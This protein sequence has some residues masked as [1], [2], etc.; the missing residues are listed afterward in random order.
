VTSCV[1]ES[2]V[3]C[4]DYGKY[5]V[6][7]YDKNE[8]GERR[9]M[10]GAIFYKNIDTPTTEV[11][12]YSCSLKDESPSVITERV[13]RLYPGLYR[14]Y[15]VLRT[16]QLDNI[17]DIVKMKNLDL[18]MITDVVERV[19]KSGENRVMFEYC[20][21]NSMIEAKCTMDQE[22]MEEYYIYDFE[23]SAPDDTDIL[24][25]LD[26]GICNYATQITDFYDHFRY[27]GKKDLFEY[28]C[29]PVLSGNFLNFK[30]TIKRE[31]PQMGSEISD[32]IVL[33]TR[34]YL[35][36]NIEQGKITRF[37]FNVTP[38]EISYLSTTVEDWKDYEQ[39]EDISLNTNNFLIF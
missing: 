22:F 34:V 18:Y 16:K 7:F 10:R 1:K 27:N 3:N 17:M 30:I 28:L 15:S 8:D 19:T 29:V 38:H 21:A 11:G 32:S 25:N 31:S 39:E 14:F 6:L 13:V 23:L 24:L 26:S 9:E 20:F 4:P 2:Y 12:V 35:L 5:R 37:H 33:K 36:S